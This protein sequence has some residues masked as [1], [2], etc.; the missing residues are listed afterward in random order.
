M[1]KLTNKKSLLLEVKYMKNKL[2][3]LLQ[4][5]V[6]TVTKKKCKTCKYCMYN[7][8]CCNPNYDACTSSIYPRYYESKKI[9]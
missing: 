8:F 4:M 7:C 5:I 3:N 1:V 6:E 9:I 2:F